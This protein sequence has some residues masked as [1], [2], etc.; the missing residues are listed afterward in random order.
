[1]EGKVFSVQG[2]E[3]RSIE[4]SDDVFGLPVNEDVIW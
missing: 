4:L 2:K 1:M 3:L